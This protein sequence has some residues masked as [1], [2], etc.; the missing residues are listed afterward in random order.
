MFM[1]QGLHGVPG[2][3][4]WIYQ[5]ELPVGLDLWCSLNEAG[6]M[7]IAVIT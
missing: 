3:D 6:A 7:V 2:M 5:G 4:A 1:A